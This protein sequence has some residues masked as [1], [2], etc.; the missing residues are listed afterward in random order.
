MWRD[1]K[2]IKHALGMLKQGGTLVSLCANGPR[3]N[4]QLKPLTDHWEVLPP[5]S[6]KDEGTKASVALLVIVKE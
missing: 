5:G 6:F 4:E 3:Q 2:H 1:I